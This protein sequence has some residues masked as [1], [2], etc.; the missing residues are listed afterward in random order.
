MRSS[1]RPHDE[2]YGSKKA[3][4]CDSSEDVEDWRLETITRGVLYQSA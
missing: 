3:E 4:R 1:V 2:E